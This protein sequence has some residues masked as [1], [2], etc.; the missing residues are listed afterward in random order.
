MFIKIV[1]LS[2][3]AISFPSFLATISIFFSSIFVIDIHC[4]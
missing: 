1:R 3:I 4:K 2:P